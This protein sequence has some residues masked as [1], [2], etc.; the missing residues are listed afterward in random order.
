MNTR[1]V[2]KLNGVVVGI[3]LVASKVNVGED[4]VRHRFLQS[5]PSTISPAL[6]S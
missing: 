4:L 2:H 6:G 3:L 5:L 1:F